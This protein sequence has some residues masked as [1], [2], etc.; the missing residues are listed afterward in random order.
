MHDP[1]AYAS[2]SDPSRADRGY[3]KRHLIVL[4]RSSSSLGR[5]WTLLFHLHGR[6]GSSDDG[7][8]D[9]IIGATIGA[10]SPLG[11]ARNFVRNL[12][13]LRSVNL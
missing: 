5:Y 13:A 2:G 9:A 6:T 4:L 12:P 7:F 8:H 11:V 1:L 10:L 3:G